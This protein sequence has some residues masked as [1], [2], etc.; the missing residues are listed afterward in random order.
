MGAAPQGAGR[1]RGGGSPPSDAQRADD[2]RNRRGRS[3]LAQPRRGADRG[4]ARRPRPHHESRPR[5]SRREDRPP[6]RR[7]EAFNRVNHPESAMKILTVVAA[8]ATMITCNPA[9]AGEESIGTAYRITGIGCIRVEDA[10]RLLREMAINAA[11]ISSRRDIILL[12]E[13]EGI[14][15]RILHGR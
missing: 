1:Q 3:R 14:S 15:C 7:S 4:G 8:A 13:R 12:A 5:R 11:V 9:S 10:S 2:G 6:D